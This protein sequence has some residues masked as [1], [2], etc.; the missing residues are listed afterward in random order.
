M[1]TT[2]EV[3]KVFF[4]LCACAAESEYVIGCVEIWQVTHS[5]MFTDVYPNVQINKISVWVTLN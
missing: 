3:N 1:P 4:C 5:H 2:A